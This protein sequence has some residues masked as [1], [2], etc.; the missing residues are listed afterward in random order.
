MYFILEIIIF[1]ARLFSDRQPEAI[2]QERREQEQKLDDASANLLSSAKVREVMY[3]LD[4]SR[5]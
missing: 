5:G 3:P 2:R 4:H 1:I